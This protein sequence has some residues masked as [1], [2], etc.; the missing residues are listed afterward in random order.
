MPPYVAQVPHADHGPRVR[1][2][3]L[4]PR[5]GQDGLAGRR[6]G[7]ERGE[8]AAW[9]VQVLVGD[10]ALDDQDE[11]P[12]EL[13]GGGLVE[14]REELSPSR[15]RGPGW[16]RCTRGRPGTAPSRSSSRLG[17]VAAVMAM[18]SPSQLRPAVIHKTSMSRTKR[19]D[20]GVLRT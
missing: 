17:C 18:E 19:G 9:L 2:E 3:T 13:A 7:A 8:V 12:V 15:R 5:R 10:R 6:I 11:R 20:L 16:C 1:R 14:R 4:Q